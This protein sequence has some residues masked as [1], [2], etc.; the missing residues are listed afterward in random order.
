MSEAVVG[1]SLSPIG[2]SFC[3]QCFTTKN[4]KIDKDKYVALMNTAEAHS[5]VHVCASCGAVLKTNLSVKGLWYLRNHKLPSV[6]ANCTIMA[7]NVLDGNPQAAVQVIR[8]LNNYI[9]ALTYYRGYA[10][11][12]FGYNIHYFD[13]TL[14]QLHVLYEVFQPVAL[15]VAA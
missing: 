1:Y 10:T 2:H 5:H 4:L 7:R 3:P 13:T 14:N 9:D 15:E 8:T 6:L 12:A 11:N